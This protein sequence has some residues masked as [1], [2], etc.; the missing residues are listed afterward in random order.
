[1]ATIREMLAAVL[2]AGI[3]ITQSPNP[4]HDLSDAWLKEHGEEIQRQYEAL[5]WSKKEEERKGKEH[6]D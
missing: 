6:D 1:M 3:M 4:V 5:Q 2:A